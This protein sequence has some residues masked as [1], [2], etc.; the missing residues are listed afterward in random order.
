M[1]KDPLELDEPETWPPLLVPLLR[2]QL[3]LLTEYAAFERERYALLGSGPSERDLVMKANPFEE[4]RNSL[5]AEIDTCVHEDNLLS[6][7]CTRLTEDELATV[8]ERGLHCLNEA[9]AT[10]R[11]AQRVA[12][13]DLTQ[14]DAARLLDRMRY[15]IAAT[16]GERLDKIWGV[17]SPR[18]LADE[19][20]L[21][22]PLRYWGGEAFL[23]LVGSDRERL[24]RLGTASIVEFEA[25]IARLAINEL[26][27]DLAE[28][29]L[30]LFAGLTDVP[31]ASVCVAGNIPA[32]L[33]LNIFRR[34][35]EEFERLTECSSWSIPL[36]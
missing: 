19:D 36:S 7:H 17:P 15:A 33:V 22:N 27:K 18:A 35:D 25:P 24:A 26:A 29:F 20:G 30:H 12:A 2:E 16:P 21:G 31:G 11:L 28:R 1:S 4:A 6:Y 8:R 34:T 5:F 3:G 14:T 9:T 10:E 13:G 23:S 32:N